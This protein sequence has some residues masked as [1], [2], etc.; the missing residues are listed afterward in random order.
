VQRARWEAGKLS[1]TGD[2]LEVMNAIEALRSAAGLTAPREVQ[3]KFVERL[4]RI[5]CGRRSETVGA[6]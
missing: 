1:N 4:A 6:S 3:I 5:G 2:M